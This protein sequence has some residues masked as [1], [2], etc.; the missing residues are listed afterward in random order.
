[1][2]KIINTLRTCYSSLHVVFKLRQRLAI[3]TPTAS[4]CKFIV[5]YLV[6]RCWPRVRIFKMENSGC[7]DSY[8]QTAHNL[9]S[10]NVQS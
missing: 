6:K 3:A 5:Y 2:K 4:T 7:R 9:Q 10:V 1:V 8:Q